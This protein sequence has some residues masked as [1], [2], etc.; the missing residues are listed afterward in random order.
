MKQKINAAIQLVPLANKQEAIEKIDETIK[1]IENSGLHY[2]VCPFE[3]VITGTFEEIID[4]LKK[5]YEASF[6][7]KFNEYLINI[8]LHI[9]T[10][11]NLH[12]EKNIEKYIL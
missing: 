10:K 4:L 6:S 3:T 12:F 1:I 9:S 2:K 7:L 11:E 5:I 8:K